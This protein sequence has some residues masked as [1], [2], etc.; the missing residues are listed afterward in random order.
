MTWA[1]DLMAIRASLDAKDAEIERLRLALSEAE[2]RAAR[3]E[4]SSVAA[5][6]VLVERRRQVE[7]EGWT[8]E[9][10]DRHDDGSLALVAALY[11]SPLPLYEIEHSSNGVRWLDP[12]PW[13]R[14]RTYHRYG[15]GDPT[16][17]VSDG[18]KRARK[19][20]REALVVAGAL[21]LAEIERLDRATLAAAQE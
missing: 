7:T 10:D 14:E 5:R 6:D 9:H 1:H 15:E 3:A 19:G 13:K 17:L 20:R 16:Y 18:D 4:A 11:A 8:P 12:W 2:Q 21:I